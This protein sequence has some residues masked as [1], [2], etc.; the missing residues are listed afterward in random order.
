MK[1]LKP[2]KQE[3]REEIDR[4]EKE[5]KRGDLG[6][7]YSLARMYYKGEGIAENKEKALE[8]YTKSAEQGNRDAQYNLGC[9]YYNGECGSENKEKAS[10]LFNKSAEQGYEAAQLTLARMYH[11]GKGVTKNEEK[12]IGWYTKAAEQENVD[13]QNDLGVIFETSHGVFQD[14]EKAVERYTKAAEHGNSNAQYNLGRMLY[15]AEGVSEDKDKAIELVRKSV[16]QG[17]PYGQYYL[18]LMYYQGKSITENKEK[19]M[20]WL[21]KSAEQGY[22]RAQNYLTYIS[23][24]EKAKLEKDLCTGINYIDEYYKYWIYEDGEKFINP[25]FSNECGGY[26]LEVKNGKVSGINYYE[27][28]LVEI[29]SEMD[30]TESYIVI[31]PSSKKDTLNDGM[32]KLINKVVENLPTVKFLKC[33]NRK[34]T[35]EKLATGGNRSIKVHLNSVE[36]CGDRDSINGTK[37]Y[38][39][40]DIMTTGN[41]LLACKKILEDAGA[42]VVCIALG[43]TTGGGE[44]LNEEDSDKKY[45]CNLNREIQKILNNQEY[46]E[47]NFYVEHVVE[48]YEKCKIRFNKYEKLIFNK[49]EIRNRRREVYLYFIKQLK[50]LDSINSC[51]YEYDD[52]HHE[53]LYVLKMILYKDLIYDNYDTYYISDYLREVRYFQERYGFMYHISSVMKEFKKTRF[54]LTQYSKEYFDFEEKDKIDNVSCVYNDIAKGLYESDTDTSLRWALENIN[55]AIELSP[56]ER[57]LYL[58]RILILIKMNEIKK[59]LENIKQII[60]IEDK[61]E[62]YIVE[63]VDCKKIILSCLEKWNELINSAES[64]YL[65]AMFIYEIC[66]S[67][68]LSS[69]LRFRKT[70][71]R[72][73]LGFSKISK[74]KDDKLTY[75]E[76][77]VKGYLSAANKM[78]NDGYRE[79]TDTELMYKSLENE[80]REKSFRDKLAYEKKTGSCIYKYKKTAIDKLKERQD[81]FDNADDSWGDDDTCGPDWLGG[82]QSE[83]EF[84]DH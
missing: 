5:V 48:K 31:V 83:Q 11:Y 29:F 56:N 69:D 34:Y 43:K 22:E 10:E 23:S 38:L 12:A 37:I 39:I 81:W 54:Y 13:A 51:D 71:M 65:T 47:P 60:K 62:I 32:Y 53:K 59:V 9:M 78:N 44:K 26:I 1:S 6:A 46:N 82:L 21:K 2:V 52:I 84:W 61:S 27:K 79:F 68:A 30:I 75:Y 17:N 35:I 50:Y 73:N 19:A 28:R 49:N 41:S 33:L 15:N 74:H 66:L 55:K 80:Y 42:E 70:F 8:L 14:K 25:E 18:G 3:N 72:S 58:N 57:N 77:K 7:Q 20:E 64:N 76:N 45:L 63:F 67:R 40:D 16:E 36:L 4:L 24:R